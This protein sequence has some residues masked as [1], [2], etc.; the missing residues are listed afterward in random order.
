[1]TEPMDRDDIEG[2]A[3]AAYAPLHTE[4]WQP[5]YADRSHESMER[6]RKV[7][8]G[9]RDALVPEGYVVVPAGTETS[10]PVD[11]QGLQAV[12]AI[13]GSACQLYYEALY[14]E[15]LYCDD[16]QD[17]EKFDRLARRAAVAARNIQHFVFGE[18]FEELSSTGQ[19]ERHDAPGVSVF[20]E[21]RA[22]ELLRAFADEVNNNRLA[23]TWV[24]REYFNARANTAAAALLDFMRALTG[25]PDAGT[26]GES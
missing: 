19:P 25:Q 6:Y 7:A 23:K 14:C 18:P 11:R 24:Y 8:I 4:S 16:V 22:N 3:K 9:V 13:Y 2:L 10:D 5:V 21:K 20:D 12:V 1:M 26:G 17:E 15:A